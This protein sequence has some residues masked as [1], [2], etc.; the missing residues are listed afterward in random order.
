M[1][2]APIKAG[3]AWTAEALSCTTHKAVL[4]ARLLHCAS[5]HEAQARGQQRKVVEVWSTTDDR[6]PL[7]SIDPLLNIYKQD[8]SKFGQLLRCEDEYLLKDEHGREPR[9]S[10]GLDE[11]GTLCVV[12]KPKENLKPAG[13]QK[14]QVPGPRE[15]ERQKDMDF[16]HTLRKGLHKLGKLEKQEQPIRQAAPPSHRSKGPVIAT[17]VR[18]EGSNAHTLEVMTLS[19][20]D[21]VLLL[22]CLFGVIAFDHAFDL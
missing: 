15:L 16:A 20:V 21:D 5:G 2:L 14:A 6:H 7:A 9:W 10:M 22:V 11:D 3:G 13:N 8:G 19:G 17:V 12:W 1:P 4:T 18:P